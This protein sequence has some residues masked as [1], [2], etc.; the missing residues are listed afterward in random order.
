MADFEAF[1]ART[2]E[3]GMEVALD[4]ALQAAPDHRG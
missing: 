3:L 1:V 4:F 2:R